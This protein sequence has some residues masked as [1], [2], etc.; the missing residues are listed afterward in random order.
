[1]IGHM[2]SSGH[3]HIRF[4]RR[5]EHLVP[6]KLKLK[7]MIMELWE[8]LHPLVG[9]GLGRAAVSEIEAPNIAANLVCCG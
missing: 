8:Q 2:R 9:L 7:R 6:L 1:M 4:A 5:Y 3:T